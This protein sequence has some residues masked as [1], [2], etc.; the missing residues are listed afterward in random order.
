MSESCN[1][2]PDILRHGALPDDI[3]KHETLAE[4]KSMPHLDVTRH[5]EYKP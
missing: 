4:Y 5:D 1:G 2:T 3:L